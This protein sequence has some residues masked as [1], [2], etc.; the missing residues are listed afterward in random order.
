MYFSIPRKSVQ[1][2]SQNDKLARLI[3]EKNG[4]ESQ[5][6]FLNSIIVDLHEKNRELEERVRNMLVLGDTVNRHMNPAVVSL[7]PPRRW[8]DNCLVFDSHET[9]DCPNKPNHISN[10]FKSR[11]KLSALIDQKPST[12]IYCDTCGV[13]DKHTTED[14]TDTQTF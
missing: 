8:C 4:A 5:V 12:R 10:G 7:R 3:E 9:E 14:C 1:P 13:F 6:A 2:S 11:R